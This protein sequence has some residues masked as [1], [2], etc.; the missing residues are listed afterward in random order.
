MYDKHKAMSELMKYLGDNGT[1][2]ELEEDGF[3]EALEGEGDELWQ[4]E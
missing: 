1:G 3:L 4:E 2:E